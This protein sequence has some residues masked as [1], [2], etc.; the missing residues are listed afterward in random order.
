MERILSPAGAGVSDVD[1]Q[2]DTFSFLIH[3]FRL[4]LFPM[5]GKAV[6]F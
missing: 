4:Y 2:K 3:N 6:E 1:Y 5:L